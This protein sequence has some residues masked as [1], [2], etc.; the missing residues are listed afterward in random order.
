MDFNFIL[1]LTVVCSCLSFILR[2]LF[3]PGN[4]GWAG[5]ASLILGV[6]IALLYF[7]PRWATLVGGGL[8]ALFLLLPL[9]G[10]AQVNRLMVQERYQAAR[11]LVTGLRWLHPA[12]GW[13]E[14]PQ[15][16]RALEMGQ[17]GQMSQA[18]QSLKPQ[19]S[20]EHPMGRNATAVLLLM[21]SR[22]PELLRWLVTHVPEPALRKDPQLLMYYLRAL[23]EVGDLNGLVRGLDRYTPALKRSSNPVPLQLSR[24]FTLA[25]CGQV[26]AVDVFL[27]QFLASSSPQ[28]QQFWRLTAAWI[29]AP[30]AEM[31]QQ[32][33]SLQ[34]QT[35]DR[36]LQQ[37]IAWRLEHHPGNPQIVLSPRSQN[38][39]AQLHKT[40]RQESRYGRPLTLKP[41][42]ADMTYGLLLLNGIFFAL[43]IHSGGSKNP[44]VLE[45]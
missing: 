21:E 5:V 38:L 3:M 42:R 27:K 8:W 28:R 23:G 44:L 43:E 18:L 37:A 1:L 40:I 41:S 4:R 30:N 15:I 25:F 31:E 16:L 11:R 7:A 32:L 45:Q 26:A 9:L 24:L 6:T 13:F 35:S 20:K 36:I 17:Q 14:Q 39:L 19:G 22:W 10:F 12:D 34:A 33:R 2:T 29:A